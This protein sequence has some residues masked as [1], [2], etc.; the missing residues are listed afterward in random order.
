MAAEIRITISSQSAGSGIADVKKDVQDLGETAEKSGGGFSIMKEV[1]TG[2]MRALGSA[3]LDL[4]IGALK[5]FAGAISDG[6]ADAKENAKI[7]AQTAAVIAST[8]GAAGVSAQHIA[9][10]AS[11]LSA[12]AGKSLFGDDQIQ[13][14]ENLLLT[15][16]NIKGSALDAATAMSVDMAQALGGAPKDAAIQL[17]KALNDPIAGVSALSRV[18]VTFTDEQ[19]ATIATMMQ[20]GDVSGAQGVILAELNK[21]FGGSAA[22][23]AAADG[24]LGTIQ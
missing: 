2:A 21:E 18:G 8:G 5:D 17:G 20:M 13:Q 12:A 24:G 14:S 11:A 16:S 7:Q 19:K 23:A 22:A 6:I 9:D 3:V 15:F 1:A 10:Y 4:G